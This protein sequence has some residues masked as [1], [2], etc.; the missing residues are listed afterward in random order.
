[1][2]CYRIAR[3]N[4]INFV[5]L[6]CS[7]HFILDPEKE[8]PAKKPSVGAAGVGTRV[9]PKYENLLTNAVPQMPSL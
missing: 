3:L 8:Y 7:Q 2:K 5:I 6:Y 1:M 4:G 9:K